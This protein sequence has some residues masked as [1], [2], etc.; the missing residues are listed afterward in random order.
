[1]ADNKEKT[2]EETVETAKQLINNVLNPESIEQ[3][4]SETTQE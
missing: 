4:S 2:T 3:E 1:M